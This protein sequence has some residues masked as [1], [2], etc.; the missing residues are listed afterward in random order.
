MFFKAQLELQ[1]CCPT[2]L[3]KR[4]QR[5]KYN[6][7]K[8]KNLIVWLSHTTERDK[9]NLGGGRDIFVKQTL[10]LKVSV[11]VQFSFSFV[12]VHGNV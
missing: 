6:S 3:Q 8:F 12:F 5:S 10:F 1:S 11:V 2:D 7:I 4:K 9:S